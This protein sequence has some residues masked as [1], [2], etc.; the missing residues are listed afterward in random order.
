MVGNIFVRIRF[1][2]R[3]ERNGP[4][5]NMDAYLYNLAVIEEEEEENYENRDG[6]NFAETNRTRRI[7][8]EFRPSREK[9]REFVEIETGKS[10][11]VRCNYFQRNRKTYVSIVDDRSIE[12]SIDTGH[13]KLLVV[14]FFSLLYAIRFSFVCRKMGTI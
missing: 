10:L 14:R 6:R 4:Y 12:R 2:G 11:T 7:E 3:N 8:C 5:A 13:S 9:S 1:I